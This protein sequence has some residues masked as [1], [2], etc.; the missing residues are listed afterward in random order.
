MKKYVFLLFAA[1]LGSVTCVFAKDTLVTW[2]APAGV[3]LNSDFT[4]KVRQLDGEWN[5]LSTYLIKVDEV[6]DTKHYVERASMA[7]FDFTG[8]VEVAVTYNWGEVQTAKV[9]PLSYDIPFQINGNT[10]TF[11]LERP[12]NLSV[13]VNGDIFHNLQP[14]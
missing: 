4:V 14:S 8:K 10:V 11:T 1:L 13:E 2:N 9:R 12:R 7:T 3:A 6:R 5:I